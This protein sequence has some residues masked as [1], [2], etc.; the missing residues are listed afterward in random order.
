MG[1]VLYTI[2][3]RSD[4]SVGLERATVNRKVEGSIP[5]RTA[6]CSSDVVVAYQP[7][8]LG[9]RVQFPAGAICNIAI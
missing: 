5:S 3:F 9:S 6:F 2:L 8:K 7:S 4:S 1:G